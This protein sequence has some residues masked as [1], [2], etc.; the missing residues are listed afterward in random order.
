MKAANLSALRTGCLYPPGIIPGIHFCY[1]LNQ[2]QHHSAAGR[3]MSTKNSSDTI[4]NRT[5]DLPASSTEP[6]PTVPPRD[7][8]VPI[9]S[10]ITAVHTT[11]FCIFKI[12]FTIILFTYTYDIQ[13]VSTLWFL[14]MSLMYI[15]Q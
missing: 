3:I 6:Q 13:V 5:C 12:H 11:T 8:L 1:R 2:P 10:E 7:S 4:R 15:F 9:M 14:H